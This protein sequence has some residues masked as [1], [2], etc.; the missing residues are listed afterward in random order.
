MNTANLKSQLLDHL[1]QAAAI[2]ATITT[3]TSSRTW[4]RIYELIT[5][6]L[7]AAKAFPNLIKDPTVDRS[8]DRHH[9]RR[10]PLN[11]N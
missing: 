10:T 7:D 5:I 6:P 8:R 2:A 4:R 9:P 1:T 3:Q 11:S